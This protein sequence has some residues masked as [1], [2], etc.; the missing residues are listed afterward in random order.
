LLT[1][2]HGDEE[3]RA[4]RLTLAVKNKHEAERALVETRRAIALEQPDL[5]DATM[6]RLKRAFDE[7]IRRQSEAERTKTIA[8]TELRSDGS[9]DPDHDLAVATAAREAAASALDGVRRHAQAIKLL[10]ELFREEQQLFATTFTRP[11]VETASQYLRALY[12]PETRLD[13][14]F[15]DGAFSDLR[16]TRPNVAGG[17]AIAFDQLS[18]GTKEQVAVALRLAMAEI[19]AADHGGALPLILDDAFANADS[20][21]VA[22]LQ[23]MLDLAASR[24]LQVIVI[25]CTPTDYHSLGALHVSLVGSPRS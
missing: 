13:V 3:T 19:L 1:Q 5:L 4:A 10:D 2:T 23:I 9:I 18:G 11:L 15:A 14:S 20:A 7:A 21:R 12:G 22:R 6:K 8:E 24:G 17:T 16:L 25:T